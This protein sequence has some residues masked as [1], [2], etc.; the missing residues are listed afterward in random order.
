MDLL[1][2]NILQCMPGHSFIIGIDAMLKATGLD[3]SVSKDTI[4]K[5]SGH[6]LSRYDHVIVRCLDM[7]I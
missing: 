5:A 2:L 4:S 6:D 1:Y 3:P 7:N